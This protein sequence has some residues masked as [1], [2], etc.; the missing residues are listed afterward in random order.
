MV[1][2][3]VPYSR[4]FRGLCFAG[5]VDRLQE[6][7]VE[8][9]DRANRED[10]P[11]EPALL[12]CLPDDEEKAVEIAELLLSFG[13]D[14]TFRNPLGQTSAQVARRRGLDDAPALLEDAAN[15]GP[16]DAP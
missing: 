12:F 15:Q 9:P 5:A 6:L 14:P 10:R 8:E 3:L 2:L 16:E 11:G 4:N 13:A 7:L 1:Q